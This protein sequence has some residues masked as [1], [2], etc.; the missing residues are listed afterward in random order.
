MDNTC[1]VALF[2]TASNYGIGI[3][4][5]LS[6]KPYTKGIDQIEKQN[7]FRIRVLVTL[8]EDKT[9]K[10]T[11]YRNKYGQMLESRVFLCHC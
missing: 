8:R 3:L 2:E 5:T 7:T 9:Q 11:I 1:S 10:N 4:F 6:I